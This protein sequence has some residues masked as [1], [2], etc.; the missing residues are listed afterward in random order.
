MSPICTLIYEHVKLIYDIKGFSFFGYFLV[1][2]KER[3]KSKFSAK[4]DKSKNDLWPE[5]WPVPYDLYQFHYFSSN[6]HLHCILQ[7]RKYFIRLE[8]RKCQLC[9]FK[10]SKDNEEEE[11]EEEIILCHYTLSQK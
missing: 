7:N 11:N 6:S 10:T 4:N 8:L 2:K 9:I 5:Y 1:K 3:K